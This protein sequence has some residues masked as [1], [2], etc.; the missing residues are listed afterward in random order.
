MST[1]TDSTSF[2]PLYG[3]DASL[4]SAQGT[5]AAC[6]LITFLAV[7]QK[8]KIDILPITW[9]SVPQPIG[10][11]ATGVVNEAL[12]NLGTSFAFKRVRKEEG[13]AEKGIIQALISEVIVL[14]HPSLRKHPNIVKLH[15]VCWDVA[16]DGSIWPVLVFEKAQ[17]GDLYNFITLPIGR[18][19]CITERLKLC[20]DVGTAILDMHFNKI[21]H[22]DVNPENILV[23][24]DGTGAY[25]AKVTNFGYSTKF[26]NEDEFFH[27]LKSSPWSAPEHVRDKFTPAQTQKM[28]VFSFAMLCLWV[29]FEQYLSGIVPFPQE[30]HWAE[31]YFQGKEGRHLSKRILEDLKQRDELVI[32][33]RQLIMAERDLDDDRKQAL[34]R[35]FCASLT[36]NPNERETNFSQSLSRLISHQHDYT[37]QLIGPENY[38]FQV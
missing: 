10:A 31:K 30:A 6:D 22:G 19:L 36:C 5:D 21:I 14:S 24:K 15:G 29:V 33:S 28:D 17:Y 35:F 38:G 4:Q 8:L 2:R 13:E 11:G 37:F 20:V 12:I 32:L 34:E 7:I 26:E 27:V 18:E 23:F 9:Q 16:S 1:N 3:S 25:T